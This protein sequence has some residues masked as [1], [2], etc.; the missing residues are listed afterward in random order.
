[1]QT[2]SD[3]N[4]NRIAQAIEYLEKNFQRQPELDEVAEQV[5]VSPFHFQRMFTE[6]AG[7]SPKR[8]LQYLTVDFLKAKLKETTTLAD[9]ADAAGLS[10]QSRV[11]DLFTTLEA[12]TPQE[13]KQRGGITIQYGFVET[14]FGEAL[15]G[16][17][18]RGVCWLSFIQTDGDALEN[19]N[20]MKSYWNNSIFRENSELI[21]AYAQRIF[22]SPL[23]LSR[24]R[25]VTE[26][27][28]RPACRTGRGEGLHLF[29]KGTNFQIKVWE[30]LLR[31]PEGNVT[32]YQTIATKIGNPKALQA[33]GSAVGANHIAYLIPCHRV[34]RKDGILGEYRWESVRKKSIIGWE[35]ARSEQH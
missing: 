15:L 14:R 27:R 8:F 32:T 35:M 24:G 7:I 1:M 22:T 4:Y 28:G 31:L 9:A 17:S 12:V 20:E 34:I 33:V 29:V 30:A 11:Y 5:H 21:K 10:S 16:V 26:E 18:E 13:Y 23:P 25:G 6:W 19:L 3:L 2:Q